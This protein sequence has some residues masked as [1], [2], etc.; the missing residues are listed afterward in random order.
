MSP[1]SQDTEVD[2]G[3]GVEE[4]DTDCQ[5]GSPERLGWW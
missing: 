4:E 5:W 3:G 1:F 2:H